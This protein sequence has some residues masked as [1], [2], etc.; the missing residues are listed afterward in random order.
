MF[1]SIFSLLN[2]SIIGTRNA[3]T[4]PPENPLLYRLM[5]PCRTEIFSTTDE[6]RN[7]AIIPTFHPYSP[8]MG[9]SVVP[10]NAASRIFGSLIVHM[11]IREPNHI[12]KNIGMIFLGCFPKAAKPTTVKIPA[13]TGPLISPFIRST[14]AVDITPHIPIFMR[15]GAKPTICTKS[16]TILPEYCIIFLTLLKYLPFRIYPIIIM[17]R[18]RVNKKILSI[19]VY[20]ELQIIRDS[21]GK[22]R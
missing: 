18:K 17:D 5:P 2:A 13:I 7:P 14:Y 1:H 3:A 22:P 16:V 21:D 12:P 15:D 8:A 19:I 20:S 10:N 9:A 6:W 11:D 4:S